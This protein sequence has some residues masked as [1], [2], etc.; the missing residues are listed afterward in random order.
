M[1]FILHR[2][3]IP[4]VLYGVIVALIIP[5]QLPV[6][7]LAAFIVYCVFLFWMVWECVS[8]KDRG[9]G[10]IQDNTNFFYSLLV[11][12]VVFLA[13]TR[14]YLFVRYGTFPLGYD[15]GFYIDTIEGVISELGR[16]SG[17]SSASIGAAREVRNYM[18]VPF[19]WL[20]I[21]SAYVLNGFYL[22]FQ[23]LLGGSVYML[24]RS[25]HT[26][27]RLIYGSVALFLFSVSIPQFFAFWW[28]FYQM[29]FAVA[30]LLMT[31]VLL[32]RRSILA[33]VIGGFGAVL[34]PATFFPFG[35]A[36]A[37][38]SIVQIVRSLFARKILEKETV[39]ILVS[40]LIAFVVVRQF[41]Q[42]FILAYTGGATNDYGWLLNNF[43]AQLRVMYSGL[44]IDFDLFQ[45][46]N[47]YLLPFFALGLPLFILGKIRAK[48][49][50]LFSPLLLI[51]IF[52]F[53]LFVLAYFPFI[54]RNRFLIILDITMIIFAVY[55]LSL[56]MV[57]LLKD[58]Q[59]R[60]M[61][62][63]LLF[64]FISL[65]GYIVWNQKPQLYPDELA[66]IKAINNVAQPMDYAMTTE[67]IYTPWVKAF[68]KRETIDPGFL[69]ANLWNYAMWK[70]F[71][72]GGSNARRHELLRMYDRPI[73]I[74]MGNI[75]PD[76]V[77]YK[78]LIVSDPSF[79][80][81]SPHV[82]RYDPNAIRIQ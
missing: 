60:V 74:F 11:G 78:R 43:P 17:F 45:L 10:S 56:L 4:F 39:F 55:P 54:Y 48:H 20:G 15:T 41:G 35:I 18:W 67:S 23:F 29:E 46:A 27:S 81:I 59:G 68:S 71:W 79:V 70:E 13:A 22:L 12:A 37:L 61:L 47:I 73:Y 5:W 6:W 63:L 1:K 44:Y 34:H 14:L 57:R 66:E 65:N 62:S 21:P 58:H 77:A 32:Q 30:L 8:M 76:D 64:G 26:S 25:F 69:R 80:Q 36:L 75:V 16:G 51:L 40:V 3:A 7:I 82:W 28:M 31:I 50:M 24:A 53:T 72:E 9:P 52:L 42:G 38:F 33:V 49:T 2:S 19:L